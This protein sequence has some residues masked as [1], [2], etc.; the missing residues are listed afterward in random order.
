MDLNPDE[1]AATPPASPLTPA[2]Q[3][4]GSS[5]AKPVQ[6]APIEVIAYSAD[7]LT[8]RVVDDVAE[9]KAF[10]DSHAVTWV[11][12]DGPAHPA[13]LAS[14]GELFKLHPLALEDVVNTSQRSK[15]DSYGQH[16]YMVTR[17]ISL[18]RKLNTEQVSLFFGTNFVITFQEKPDGDCFDAI[19]D[20]IRT[21]AGKVRQERADHLA[22]AL[23]DAVID[24]YFPVLE[25]IG[26][27]LETLEDEILEKADNLTPHK[28]HAIKRDV[29]ALRRT[30]W[31]LRD[32][33]NSLYRDASELVSAD[34]K[35]YIRD[36]YDHA[37]RIIE[38]VE[39]YRE[40]CSDL[41]QLHLSKV[42]N[43][44]NEVMKVLAI[45]TSLFIPPT[46]IASIYGMNFNPEKSPLNM[47][48]LS[49]FYGYPVAL[50]AML[51]LVL[52]LVFFLYWKGWLKGLF[53]RK[54]D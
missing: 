29:L 17:I 27:R 9:I 40:L 37:I 18:A 21:A 7:K 49:W 38:M 8:E 35:M 28:I 41:M 54:S 20:R 24:G 47:P 16:H 10:V 11:N 19:R 36:C 39:M 22:Y 12:I 30:I 23:I 2:V 45:I 43:K 32:A 5:A 53:S 46:F 26:E 3:S 48:E 25:Q 42:S 31:P 1:L 14:L 6:Y 4:G 52:A 13:V 33:V 51:V 15:V 34:T 44:M 50:A